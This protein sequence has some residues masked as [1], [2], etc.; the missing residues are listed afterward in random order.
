MQNQAS[1]IN[2]VLIAG[3]GTMGQEIGVY[4]AYA[5]CEVRLY[6]LNPN[7]L[8]G[9]VEKARDLSKLAGE[10]EDVTEPR[11][12]LLKGLSVQ[13]NLDDMLNNVDLVIECLPEKTAVKDE[14][15]RRVSPRC[16]TSTIITTNSSMLLP[17]RLAKDVTHPER[18]CAL[19]FLNFSWCVEI[20]G[21]PGTEPW[22]IE[23]LKSFARRIHH[24]PIVPHRENRGYVFNVM[25]G[26]LHFSSLTLV[27]NGVSDPED[28]DRLFMRVMHTD[29]G[30]FGIIDMVGVDTVLDITK[31]EATLTRNPQVKKNADY[32]EEFVQQGRLGVKTGHGF[33][34]YPNPT[35]RDPNFMGFDSEVTSTSEATAPQPALLDGPGRA[36]PQNSQRIEFDCHLDPQ[37]DGFFRDHVFKST[38][39]VP[40]AA[41]I[42]AMAQASRQCGIDGPIVLRNVAFTN[43]IRSFNEAPQKLTVEI[44]RSETPWKCEVYQEFKNRAGKVLDPHRLCSTSQIEPSATP[45]ASRWQ[46][47]NHT[48]TVRMVYANGGTYFLGPMMQGLKHLFVGDQG[49]A[50]E[51][52]AT[53]M[54]QVC[55]HR[56]DAPWEF[57]PP[58]LDAAL[59][60]CNAYTTYRLPGVWQMPVAISRIQI[61]RPLTEEQ[62]VH[63]HFFVDQLPEDATESEYQILIHDEQGDSLAQIDGYRC[64]LMRTAEF[65]SYQLEMC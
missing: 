3:A 22:V 35:Y 42:E 7:A 45:E 17:S 39:L 12:A 21:H 57:S 32:L 29:R 62:V 51:L 53:P 6:D 47:T 9:A 46:P 61:N 27:A 60:S 8:D 48:A 2:A 28:V 38:P 49:G 16:P 5:G 64:V 41:I 65:P 37:Q 24:V 33:Y 11:L 40:G 18:F 1:E 43:P 25:L 19:H 50:G 59:V 63:S 14:F 52:R 23:K 13:S 4:C 44:D 31:T 20:M 54:H 36:D 55:P 15:Y 56:A 34:K 10:R 30:P 26:G 58:L